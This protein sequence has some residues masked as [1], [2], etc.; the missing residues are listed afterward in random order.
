MPAA[1]APS[2]A[3]GAAQTAPA[4]RVDR[5]ASVSARDTLE[6]IRASGVLATGAVNMIGLDAIRRQLGDRWA[7]KR[8]RVWEHVEQEFQR[9]L[10]PADL[11]VRIDDINYL[12]AVPS[13]PG[14]AA[15]ALCL[16]ILQDVLKFFLGEIKTGDIAV[17]IVTDV[18]DNAIV[19]A[20]ADLARLARARAAM[21]KPGAP[22]AAIDDLSDH[23]PPP[24]D[25]RPPLAGRTSVVELALPKREPFDI[26]LTVVPVWN[27]RRGLITAFLIERAEAPEGAEAAEL[28]AIDMATFAYASTLL[29][30]H[31]TQGGGLTL[32]VPVSFSSLA[33]QHTRVRLLKLTESVR[34]AMRASMLIEV[35]GLHA[36]VPPSRLLEVAG[37]VRSLCAGVLGRVR[38]SRPALAA[39][40]ACGLR[41][42]VVEAPLLGLS[43]GDAP[44]RLKAF[45]IA[46]QAVS[47]N[48]IVHGLPAPSAVDDA[49]IAGFTH[50]SVAP[51]A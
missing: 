28:E 35:C 31:A 22:H 10:G 34:E 30:E 27:L 26:T 47:P 9:K 36:G 25:W 11:A 44:A 46:A 45:V 32:H 20:P 42:L 4:H 38:P 41:G 33:V 15:Q 40:K 8:G 48:L 3:D 19:S 13:A 12:I 1:T 5:I 7:A 43:Q 17:R 49:A 37:L 14:F 24:V 29:D 23:Q 50:A 6:R 2:L 51:A 39:V 18:V 16:T 21:T